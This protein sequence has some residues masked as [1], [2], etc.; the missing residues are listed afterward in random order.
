MGSAP[1]W[2]GTTFSLRR[3]NLSVAIIG[4]SAAAYPAHVRAQA[5]A[6][7][8]RRAKDSARTDF[9]RE[10]RPITNFIQTCFNTSNADRAE[11]GIT[12]AGH[13]AIAKHGLGRIG[14]FVGLRAQLPLHFMLSMA[15][16]RWQGVLTVTEIL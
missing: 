4:V 10:V 2:L 11:M 8:A 15:Y 3:G 16:R 5:A 9:E 6:E 13:F 14:D 1:T 12:G 7:G